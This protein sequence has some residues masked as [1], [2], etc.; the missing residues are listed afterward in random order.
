MHVYMVRH[1]PLSVTAL[2]SHIAV[3]ALV[4]RF[5]HSLTPE[6]IG[7]GNKVHTERRWN[8]QLLITIIYCHSGLVA[9]MCTVSTCLSILPIVVAKAVK[10][11]P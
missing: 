2:L 1:L 10:S 6:L 3:W 8:S 9:T 5:T 11:L 7:V 4:H